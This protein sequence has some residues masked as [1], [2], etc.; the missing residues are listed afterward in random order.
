L[1]SQ[2][3]EGERPRFALSNFAA[4]VLITMV[5]LITTGTLPIAQATAG[6]A[7][8]LVWF[9]CIRPAEA[10]RSVNLS[11]LLIIASA[12][13]IAAAVTNSG[14]ADALGGLLVDTVGGAR[15][16]VALAAI[17]IATAVAT[18][19]L[20]NVAAAALIVPIALSAAEQLGR[21]PRPFAVAVAIAASMSFITPIGYQTNLLVYGPG[22]YRFSDFMRV[23]FPMAVIAFVVSMVVIP[24]RWGWG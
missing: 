5:V 12:F 20:S 3:E 19:A 6:A 11:V 15:P 14:L 10:R 18:E 21:D 17:Y 2:V 8:L 24:W 23:G 16:W 13:G 1:V 7:V 4:F 22:G 9:R